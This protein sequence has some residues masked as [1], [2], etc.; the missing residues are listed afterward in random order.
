MR[1][2]KGGEPGQWMPRKAQLL[3]H[4]Y[5]AAGG[6]YTGQ[7][8]ANQKHLAR[9]TKEHWTTADGAKARRGGGTSRYLPEKA[10]DRLSPAEKKATNSRKRAGSRAGKQFVANTSA[11]KKAR[12]QVAS[13]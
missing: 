10:W 11:A 4:E 1:G 2:D 5:E 13:G 12:K 9:W 8:Q 6:K 3:A 7:R